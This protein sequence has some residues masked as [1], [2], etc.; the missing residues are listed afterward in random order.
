MWKF[1][2]VCCAISTPMIR[3]WLEAVFAELTIVFFNW[4]SAVSV[5]VTAFFVC[6][7]AIECLG[8]KAAVLD[9]CAC[10][11]MCGQATR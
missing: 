7:L 10:S 4:L 6:A 1:V 9:A 2:V 5:A 3:A 8:I 11:T